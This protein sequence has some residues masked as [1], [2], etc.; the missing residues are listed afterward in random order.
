MHRQLL[1]RVMKLTGGRSYGRAL[2][3][4]RGACSHVRGIIPEGMGCDECGSGCTLR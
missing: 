4:L 2:G 1:H 3:T